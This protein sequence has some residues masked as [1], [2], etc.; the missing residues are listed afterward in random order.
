VWHWVPVA[1]QALLLPLALDGQIWA[2]TPWRDVTLIHAVRQPLLNPRFIAM[3]GPFRDTIGQTFAFFTQTPMEVSRKSTGT[4]KVFA[5]WT[6]AIDAGPGAS[7]DPTHDAKSAI[8]FNVNL[9]DPVFLSADSLLLQD[10]RQ[11]FHDTKYRRVSY[12]AAAASKFVEYFRQVATVV[13]TGTSTLI[14]DV[15]G[16]VPETMKVTSLDRKTTYLRNRDYVAVDAAGTLARTVGSAIPSGGQI[17]ADY[18][19]QPVERPGPGEGAIV[20]TVDVPNSARP[21]APKV[22][23][24]VPTWKRDIAPVNGGTMTTRQGGGLRV[25]EAHGGEHFEVLAAERGDA[26]GAGEQGVGDDL[27]QLGRE[28]LGIVGRAQDPAGLVDHH[29]AR[30]IAGQLLV[31]RRLIVRLGPGRAVRRRRRRLGSRF[32]D[33]T[34]N[35]M[36]RMRASQPPSCSTGAAGLAPSRARPLIPRRSSPLGFGTSTSTR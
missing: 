9:A 33:Y 5:D 15:N 28:L 21:D 30:R 8:A 18:T 35:S 19:A 4:L 26:S 2:L 36:R 25:A 17:L 29:E 32:H 20:T 1:T 13:L 24:I 23:Y 10:E 16:F 27:E 14:V 11:E 31:E 22:L 3:P 7:V 12:R 6:E 34:Q